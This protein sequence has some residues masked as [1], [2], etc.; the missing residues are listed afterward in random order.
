MRPNPTTLVICALSLAA[1]TLPPRALGR[2]LPQE[3]PKPSPTEATAE[4]S[5]EAIVVD[6]A[7]SRATF[8]ADGSGVRETTI[9]ARVLSEAGVKLSAV[10]VFPYTTGD[11]DIVVDYVRV[12]KPDGTVVETPPYNIQDM[13]AE[14]TRS[15]PM[16][17]DLHEKHIAVKALGV[18]DTLEYRVRT[19]TSRPQTPGH[20]WFRYAFI[21]QLITND[22]ELEVDVPRSVALSLSSPQLQP[23]IREEGRRRIYTWRTSN[24]SR[25]NADRLQARTEGEAPSVQGSTFRSWED[26]GR[27]YASLQRP[28]L[29]VTPAVVAKAKALTA[30]L[31]NDEDKVRALYAYV[32][33]KI[34]YVSLSFGLGR[35]QPHAADEVL[36]NEYGDCKDK[37]TLLAALLRAAGYDAWPGLV[38]STGMIDP[39][40][41]SPGQFDHVITVVRIGSDLTWLDSTSGAAPYGMLFAPLR[42]SWALVVRDD[43]QQALT[44]TPPDPPYPLVTTLAVTAAL[45]GDGVLTAHVERSDRSD[46]E[47]ILR[48]AFR[49]APRSNWQE[50]VQQISYSGGFAGTTSNAEAS[51]PEDTTLPFSM[52][53]DYTRHNYGDWPNRQ[54]VVPSPPFALPALSTEGERPTKPI[55]LGPPSEAVLAMTV[56]LPPGY[57]L[58]PPKPVDLARPYAE[59]HARYSLVGHTLV[60]ERRLT[61]KAPEVEL[62]HLDDYKAFEKAVSDDLGGWIK[63]ESGTGTAAA[64]AAGNP[65]ATP[66]FERANAALR[67]R[68]LASAEADLLQVLKID[69]TY[70]RAHLVLGGIH[71]AKNLTERGVAEF[72]R[73]IELHPTDIWALSTAAEALTWSKRRED[74]I[75]MWRRLL[76]VDPG[77]VTAAAKLGDLLVRAKRYPEA[78]TVLEPA[79]GRAPSNA[80]LQEQLGYAYLGVGQND[81]ALTAVRRAVELNP[82][83]S[84]MNDVAYRLAEANALLEQARQWAEAAVAKVEADTLAAKLADLKLEDLDR[85]RSVADDWDTL[86]W[87][88]F[89]TGDLERAERYLRAAWA[90]SQSTT[91]GFH[92]ARVYERQGKKDQAAHVYELA[93]VAEG[94]KDDL[95]IADRYQKLTGHPLPSQGAP[96]SSADWRKAAGQVAPGEELLRARMSK[97]PSLTTESATADFFLVQEPGSKRAEV[98]FVSGSATLRDH[99]NEIAA[100]SI[101]AD[102]PD[103]GPVKLIRRGTVSCGQTGCDLVLLTPAMVRS[104]E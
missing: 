44:C 21:R 16:Y 19:V 61:T 39:A 6:R 7:V 95:G 56:D 54:I 3:Q 63:L 75:E 28:A 11:Q 37:H 91:M 36:G 5:N 17:S 71:L 47:M 4:V 88:C 50:L 24:R 52:S 93:A 20:F 49:S 77:H 59:Y 57:T 26:V 60:C 62:A 73:E 25:E 33:T 74:A 80:D 102:F 10:L 96:S 83:A 41:P 99:A 13:P 100:A 55:P 35:F 98:K 81:K 43:R 67:R 31:S 85:M 70:P 82:S 23:Q 42:D 45:S 101:L 78:V 46:L 32:S 68:D 2:P 92:L 86:G 64:T 30:G 79:V 90:L 103:N 48:A 15:A 9:V 14:V 72:R 51:A 66:L 76:T 84:T 40:V 1:A 29:T 94:R 87:V 69:P 104:L 12:R 22:E 97:L 65:E 34:H 27:W 53:W 38:N 89:R 58:T 18:G 8:E